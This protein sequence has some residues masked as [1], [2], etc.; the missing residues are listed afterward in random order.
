M[1]NRYANNANKF[2][3]SSEG[4]SRL[5]IIVLGLIV[6]YPLGGHTWQP[7]QY[8]MGLARLGHEVYFVEDSGDYPFCYNP[9]TYTTDADASYGLRFA[10]RT[11]ADVGLGE[12]WAYYHAPTSRWIGP[13]AH[14]ISHVCKSADLLLN[15]SGVNT[16]RPW[17]M[18]IPARALVDTDPVFT[19]INH[20]TEADTRDGALQHTAFLSFGE[21]I[22]SP[23]STTPDD[24]LPWQPTRQPIVL[25]AWSTAPGPAQ[26]RFTTV[27]QW[28][29]YPARKYNGLRYGM[30]SDSFVPY[31]DLPE[32][33]GHILELAMP[34]V[35]EATPTMLQCKGWELRDPREPTREPRAYQRYIRNSKAEFSVAKH[36]YVI[37]RSGWFSER[38]ACYLASG[39]PVVT[40][41]TGF[42]DW[43]QSSGGVIPFQTPDEAVAAIGEINNRYEYHCRT[44]RAVAEEYFDARRVLSDLLE[45]SF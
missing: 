14:R 39:R 23:R 7:L 4:S 1:N 44:A 13:C 43:L 30:K 6:R 40:Q 41:E 24:G 8:V 45:R 27:M 37:S 31:T 36:G 35:L 11:F 33:V 5:R 10:T 17:L 22:G 42:S 2:Q 38:S 25:D 21:N 16:L 15:L 26:G 9:L 32:R 29:S 20:L 28:N 34:G 12:R 3:S 18:A 19:Q